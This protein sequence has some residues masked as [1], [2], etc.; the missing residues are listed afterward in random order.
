MP[1]VVDQ[2]DAADDRR[3]VDRPAVGL[4][5]EGDV[6]RDDGNAER[7]TG[8]RHALDGLGELP[9]DLR[10]LRV[11]EVEAVGQRERAAAGTGDVARG[12]EDGERAAGTGIE[13]GE[14]AGAVE[15][16]GD[17]PERGAQ[18]QHGR[19]EAGPS[20]R[21]RLDELVVLAVDP[22]AARDVR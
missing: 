19:V 4:V 21:S 2:A 8:A 13:K 5:V 17:A 6:A 16:H 20:H 3:R 15:R 12:L 11:S 22:R 18:L 9:G 7:L 10:L 14:P 1:Y